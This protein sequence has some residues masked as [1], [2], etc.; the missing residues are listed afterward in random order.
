MPPVPLRAIRHRPHGQVTRSGLAVV[1]DH[2]GPLAIR[3]PAGLEKTS[4]R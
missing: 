3:A 1:A 4:L 2:P